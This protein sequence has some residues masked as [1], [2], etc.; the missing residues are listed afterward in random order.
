MKKLPLLLGLAFMVGGVST[1]DANLFTNPGFETGDLTGWTITHTDNGQT[2]WQNVDVIDI[3]GGGPHGDSYAGD[4]C[5]GK[6]DYY[7]PNGGINLTQML[8]LQVGTQ[9]TIEYD[10]AIYM[11]YTPDWDGNA[12]AGNFSIVVNGNELAYQYN[13]YI[14][15]DTWIYGHIS[16]TYTPGSTG[17]YDVGARIVREYLSS[18]LLHQYVDNFYIT[19]APGALALLGLAGLIGRRRR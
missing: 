2:L 8:N 3:D 14:E 9:Y 11:E 12:N 13:G 5:V 15:K 18:D 10:Y 4:F 16:A 17:A 19:P 7:G 1:A 6:I